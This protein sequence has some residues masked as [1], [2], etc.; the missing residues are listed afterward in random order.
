MN[1]FIE[2]G[3]DFHS[4]LMEAICNECNKKQELCLITSLPL[5]K[6]SYYT[7]MQP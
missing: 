5:K 4:E 7:I 3:G 2:G 6:K 1:Y